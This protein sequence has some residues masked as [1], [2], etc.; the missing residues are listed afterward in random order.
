MRLEFLP[1]K[2]GHARQTRI[3][4]VV[5]GG[6]IGHIENDENA[7]WLC[8]DGAGKVGPYSSVAEAKK[9]VKA[10]LKKGVFGRA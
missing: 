5:G 2:T 1:Q 4:V 3:I 8:L 9:A 10:A 6:Q 7:L